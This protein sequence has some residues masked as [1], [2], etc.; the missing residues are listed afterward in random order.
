[1]KKFK[2]LILVVAML[3]PSFD[4]NAGLKVDFSAIGGRVV[5]MVQEISDKVN[6]K[7][8]TVAEKVQAFYTGSKLQTLVESA[9]ALK[10]D[11]AT[12]AASVKDTYEGAQKKIDEASKTISDLKDA[13]DEYAEKLG[14]LSGSKTSQMTDLTKQLTSKEQE[15]ADYKKNAEDKLL[16]DQKNTVTNL[17]VLQAMYAE[18]T[19]DK[20]KGL[21]A[22]QILITEAD[23]AGYN[24]Q[25]KQFK[26]DEDAFFKDDENYQKLADDKKLLQR[27]LA[28]FGISAGKELLKS[29][30]P[31]L[32]KKDD[33]QKSAE[34]NAMIEE[35]FLLPDDAEN[36]DN[37]K[38]VLKNRN[39]VLVA[40]IENAFLTSAKL[41]NGFDDDLERLELKKDNMAAVD[42]KL[43]SANLLIEQRI[44]DINILYKY[45]TLMI[46][47][48]RLKTSLNIRNQKYK[49]DNYDKDPAV[50]NLDNY[51]MTSE[52]IET[53]EFEK[54][55]LE[56]LTGK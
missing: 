8:N 21:L 5:G 43:T 32:L 39:K 13:K 24:E 52:D 6:T 16:A 4:A 31:S 17:N 46:A 37:V 3:L 42:S 48:M 19:D 55:P 50:L 26:D 23:L 51:I 45:T 29:S 47:D 25:A 49:L 18:E 33:K 11:V 53:D 36:E 38:R 10:K 20:I 44:E 56:G 40:D 14:E 28:E 7:V 35:N 12:A 15:I 1:M 54:S 41:K 22:S 34:Y 27:Q 30:F 9:K 2:A